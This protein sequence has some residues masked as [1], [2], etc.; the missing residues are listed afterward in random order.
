M[1]TPPSSHQAPAKFRADIQALRGLAIIAVLLYHAKSRGFSAGYLGVDMFFVIS[2]FLITSHIR[3]AI[4]A[5]R[6]TLTSFYFRRIKRLLPAAYTVFLFTLLSAPYFLTAPEMKDFYRQMIGAI[7]FTAN[8]ALKNQT[9]YFEGAADLKPL[10][11]TWSLSIEEQYYLLI[12]AAMLFV[13]R[14]FWR[15]GLF[16][17]F[18]TSLGIS[19]VWANRGSDGHF[20]L[21]TSRAWELMIG[22]IG[23]LMISGQRT[24]SF[25]KAAF[26]PALVGLV[27]LPMMTVK[28]EGFDVGVLLICLST[29]IVILRKHPVLAQ[30]ALVSGLGWVG[31]ISYSLYLV[32]WPLLA[33]L[34]NAWVSSRDEADTVV[35]LGVVCASVILAYLLH[36]FVEK[37]L[38]Y[39]NIRPARFVT[40]IAAASVLLLALAHV[41]ARPKPAA[42]DYAAMRRPNNGFGPEC[43][44]TTKFSP[45]EACRN[46]EEPEILVWGDSYAMHLVP[47]IAA[48]RRTIQATRS[49]CG[50]LMDL[51]QIDPTK[52]DRN[53]AR[54]C[55][56]FNNSV[57]DYLRGARSVK[58]VVLSSRFGYY[59]NRDE[60][61]LLKHDR[62]RS[63]YDV[64][65]TTTDEAVGALKETVNV[66]RSLGK[67]VVV[68][69]PPP[70]ENF[71][72]GRC[73]ER[74]ETGLVIISPRHSDCQF[75]VEG[76][77]ALRGSVLDFLNALPSRADVDVVDFDEYLCG[78]ENCRTN[79]DGVFI[80]GK[81]GHL[82]NEGS[83][84]L[85][86]KTSL[87]ERIEKNAR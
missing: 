63:T 62:S 73:L 38:H 5:G 41:V 70:S 75:T 30:G 27:L 32:H 64:V 36:R 37:P 22:S 16:A 34:N 57:V 1:I 26:W 15:T 14:R 85:A 18:L 7:T 8:V 71:D 56:E 21:L 61:T 54:E 3:D 69:A 20:Y 52:D 82:S 81:G 31:N 48:S 49:G 24:S 39:S 43:S 83:L 33:F 10:L 77:R 60:A 72:A 25:I 9:G 68:V 78:P 40:A 45:T 6:F 11:H 2:G 65:E 44:F 29:M 19:V 76:Y 59:L 28:F 74:L 86:E 46:S 23:A 12:P 42:R 17:V 67:R 47:G 58:T 80:Y 53:A 13:S 55:I 87:V 51:A 84:F 50:P 66:I 35:R 79:I 4:D